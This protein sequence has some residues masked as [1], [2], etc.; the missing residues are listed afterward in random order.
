M[1]CDG[2]ACATA[3]RRGPPLRRLSRY[4]YDYRHIGRYERL[5]N[6]ATVSASGFGEDPGSDKG[7][8]N[9][10]SQFLSEVLDQLS[11][12]AWMPGVVVLRFGTAIGQRWPALAATGSRWNRSLGIRRPSSGIPRGLLGRPPPH[13]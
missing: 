10:M 4:S 7:Q 12:T 2:P 3:S 5:P 13:H 11:I 9:G 8:S 1:L 6:D